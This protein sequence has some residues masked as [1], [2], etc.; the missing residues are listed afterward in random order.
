MLR[1]KPHK[2]LLMMV[3]LVC[4]LIPAVAFGQDSAD[5]RTAVL[6]ALAVLHKGNYQF[7]LE[8][9]TLDTFTYADGQVATIAGIYNSSGEV[10]PNDEY[11]DTILLQVGTDLTQA[12]T[13]PGIQ[14]ERVVVGGTTYLNLSEDLLIYM[15]IPDITA[16]WWRSDDFLAQIED[17]GLPYS[18]NTIINYPIPS[19][20]RVSAETLLSATAGRMVTTDARDLRLYDVA[21]DALALLLS[22]P[23]GTTMALLVHQFADPQRDHGELTAV[24]S[25]SASRMV[26]STAAQ[27]FTGAVPFPDG[28]RRQQPRL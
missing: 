5:D 10:A 12:G 20:S 17:K 9:T 28:R 27:G 22:A 23:E 21:S 26:A 19:K 1:H 7:T 15:Q 11:H 18:I 13:Q 6:Q 25:G 3:L 16:G 4:L 14:I 8:E 2:Y 24:S